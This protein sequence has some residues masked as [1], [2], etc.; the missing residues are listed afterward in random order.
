V[1]NADG[2]GEL[3]VTGNRAAG[4]SVRK[5]LAR[6]MMLREQILALK[7]STD[8]RFRAVMVFPKARVEAR[9]GD[10][11]KAHC[12]RLDQLRDYIDNP[13]FSKNLSQD[14]IDELV[15]ALHSV[16]AMDE[17]SGMAIRK[18]K[19]CGARLEDGS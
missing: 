2:R 17:E 9:F 18:E 12:I 15:Q 8:F 19:T 4:A 7:H 3:K 6:A 1:I 13:K 5:F 11:G 10:T 14:R 16:A